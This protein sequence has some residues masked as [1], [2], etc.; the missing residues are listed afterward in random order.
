MIINK[1]LNIL[2]GITDVLLLIPVF[3]LIKLTRLLAY[4]TFGLI[5]IPLSLI[6]L[7][8][9]LPLIGLS[10]VYNKV[11]FLRIPIA[12]L[13]MPIAFFGYVYIDSITH[14][15]EMRQKVLKQFIC[16]SWPFSLDAQRF[17]GGKDLDALQYERIYELAFKNK[18][19]DMLL[20]HDYDNR[21][22]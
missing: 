10:W 13:G 11:T 22:N 8:F 14:M 3:I 12:I 17:A 6:W 2:L 15:G 5:L 1:I 16:I 20:D 7:A 21:V 19:C 4:L 18:M 9:Y